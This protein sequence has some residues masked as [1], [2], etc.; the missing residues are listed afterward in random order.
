MKLLLPMS[1]VTLSWST[2][3]TRSHLLKT[4]MAVFGSKLSCRISV[5]MK[6]EKKIQMS[7][8]SD[9]QKQQYQVKES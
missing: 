5:A 9:L 7:F 3:G 4:K 1:S 2:C 8:Q 6:A